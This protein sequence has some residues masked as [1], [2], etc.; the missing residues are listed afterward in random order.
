M[1][2]SGAKGRPYYGCDLA[3]IHHVGF[4]HHAAACAP[5]ILRLL[6]PVLHRGG[7]V[8]ELGCGSGLLTR[9][10]TDAGHRVIA[11]DA[12]AAMLDLARE[13]VP[14]ADLRLVVMPDDPLPEADAIVSVGHA[15][16]YL[17]DE[18]AIERALRSMAR[19][20]RP[21]GL[22]AVDVCDLDWGATRAEAPPYSRVED[23]WAIITRYSMPSR[24]RFV[25]DISVFVRRDDG[26][27]RRDD[28]RHENVLIDT[29]SV[30]AR[31]T[32][33]GVDWAIAPSFGGEQLPAGMRVLIGRRNHP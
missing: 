31:L 12:S 33:A 3:W 20:L 14:E 4:G 1:V 16:N 24:A 17:A 9:H 28:E 19:A 30:P 27:W 6:Q 21:D 13:H 5:G 18:A 7:L 32:G 8:L 26:A 29:A 25:R 2:D 15:L 23:D 11:S 22:V 10:L